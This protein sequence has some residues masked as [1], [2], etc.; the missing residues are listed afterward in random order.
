[1]QSKQI[2]FSSLAPLESHH[3]FLF[4]FFFFHLAAYSL[5]QLLSFF[6]LHLKVGFVVCEKG[7]ERKSKD[8]ET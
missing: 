7:A 4:F 8:F 1:M 5:Q 2:F 6:M 3:V